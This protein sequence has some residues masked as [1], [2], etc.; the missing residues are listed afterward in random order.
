[1]AKQFIDTLLFWMIHIFWGIN[2]Q[3]T[4]IPTVQSQE[5][6]V[7]SNIILNRESSQSIAYITIYRDM[8]WERAYSGWLNKRG[9]ITN[10]SRI[11]Y[12]FYENW[13]DLVCWT[14][15]FVVLILLCYR[16][17]VSLL[18]TVSKRM[19][20]NTCSF[21]VPRVL[22]V[23]LRSAPH[24]RIHMYVCIYIYICNI[25]IYTYVWYTTYDDCP[26]FPIPKRDIW[27]WLI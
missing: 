26:I 19:L 23:H 27:W 10:Q 21:I 13:I 8:A 18:N 16:L 24:I 25:Y 2:R 15:N 22:D 3:S 6:S 5:G 9:S 7:V 14:L 4:A 17:L 1:M 20:Q 11:S 12:T